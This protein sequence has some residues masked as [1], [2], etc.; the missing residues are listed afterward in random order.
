METIS[1]A[2]TGKSDVRCFGPY[3]INIFRKSRKTERDA[4]V[5]L[6]QDYYCLSVTV[7]DLD[8]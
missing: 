7:Q 6:K 8:L 4:D 3:L 2:I 1:V 5:M